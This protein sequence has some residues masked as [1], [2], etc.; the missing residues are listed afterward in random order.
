MSRRFFSISVR[1]RG[2]PMRIFVEVKILYKFADGTISLTCVIRE[3][4]HPQFLL[5]HY[6]SQLDVEAIF[7][8]HST[9]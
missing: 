1:A 8:A 3:K 6:L 7:L 5:V 4:N 9:G 2:D